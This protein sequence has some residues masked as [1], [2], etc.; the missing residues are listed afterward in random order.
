MDE[1]NKNL[2]WQC[3]ETLL[4]LYQR[5]HIMGILNVTP[6]SFSDGGFF[7]RI[8]KSVEQALKMVDEGADIIDIGGEST[9]PGAKPVSESEELDRVVPVIKE[10]VKQI[11]IPVSIDTYKS[12]VAETALQAG[13]K[14][15]NDISGFTFDSKMPAVVSQ[16]SAGCVLMHIK[17]EPRNMQTNPFYKNVLA[18]ITEYLESSIKI[19]RE[20]GISEEQIVIDPGIGFGKR[21]QDNL[22]IIRDL[23]KLNIVGRPILVGPSRKSFIGNILDADINQRLEGTAAAVAISI[24]NG[25]HIVRVHDVK[26]MKKVALIVDALLEK[27]SRH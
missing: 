25:A 14:I 26:E 21:L 17:G 18:E 11:S 1:I 20:H 8:E 16:H 2:Y 23:K 4:P 13:A 12:Q 6:D 22:E 15:V 9:R 3:K 19:A 27:K 24:F 7:F 5:T 10:L